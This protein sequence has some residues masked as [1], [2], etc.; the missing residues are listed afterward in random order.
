METQSNKIDFNGQHIYA[1]FDVH[2]KSWQVTILTE[3]LTHRTF[4]Q[5]PSPETLHNYLLRNF[6][7]GI[8]HTAYEAGFCGYWIQ[9]KL[10]SLGVDSIVFNAAD[11]PTSNKEKVQ[12]TDKRD[13]N[14]IAK[15]L[16]NGDLK[17]IYIP[18][19]KTLEDRGLIRTRIMLVRDLARYKSRIKSFLYFRGLEIP[20][21]FFKSSYHW[22]KRFY[23]WLDGVEMS[24]LS[25]KQSLAAIITETKNLRQSILLVTRQIRELSETEPYKTH[26][27]LLQTI[28]GIGMLTAM[29]I[30]TELETID[31]F[32]RFDEL[33]G[34]IGMVPSTH[35]SGE[36]EGVGK[37]TPR[38]HNI[39]RSAIIESSWIAARR[40]P[41]LNKS[42]H[43]YCKRMDPNKAI[44]RIA[45]KLLNRV[46]FVLKNNKPYDYSTIN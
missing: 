40:D 12:K 24:E 11:I 41:I 27:E 25:G 5:P 33:C 1:G 28:P 36:T 35:S 21:V 4:S 8:Y 43:E 13:S 6:P 46:R 38:G 37:I 42:Y 9:N 14:K 26:R 17:S 32:H 7:G 3:K 20:L 39:L 30:L 15:A 22:S 16:R 10:Q 44:I 2:L 18:S 23:Q 29:I 31:R 19:T 34:F 45:R